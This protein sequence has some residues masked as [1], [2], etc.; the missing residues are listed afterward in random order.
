MVPGFTGRSM[1]KAGSGTGKVEKPR[2]ADKLR[3]EVPTSNVGNE[4]PKEE[5]SADPAFRPGVRE[6]RRITSA[7]RQINCY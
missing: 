4:L 3:N 7:V 6:L 2:S 1:V 5:G